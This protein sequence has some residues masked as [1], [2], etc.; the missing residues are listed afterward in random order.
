LQPIYYLTVL[1]PTKDIFR[2]IDKIR[3]RFLWAGDKALSGGNGKINWT[4]TTLP[5]EFGGLGILNLDRFATALRLRWLWHEWASPEKAWVGMEVPCT[6]SDRLLFTACTT[7]SISN[8]R[9]TPFWTSGW[10]HGLRPKDLAPLL[11]S[12][13]R[14]KKRTVA[15]AL[16]NK[17]WIRDLNYRTGFTTM[18]LQQFVTLWTLLAPI[19]LQQQE[20]GKLTWRFTRSGEYTSASSYKAQFIGC[21][22]TLELES[23]WKTWATPS[24]RS[25]AWLIFQNRV[26][27]SNRLDSRGW[28]HNPSCP[29]CRATMETT[30]HLVSACRF[31]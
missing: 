25:F 24:C 29:L 14:K 7:I 21:A 28:D 22:K 12:K 23:I 4:K 6:E 30:H 2:A 19:E 20:D 1:K 5:T 13:T 18:H 31:T 9:R 3:R 16:H 27:T 26:W 10:L 8:G 15:E 17:T 11:F